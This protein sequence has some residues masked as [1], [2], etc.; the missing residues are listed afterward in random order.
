MKPLGKVAAL[1]T[2]ALFSS[3]SIADTISINRMDF[4]D[5]KSR[6]FKANEDQKIEVEYLAPVYYRNEENNN[7]DFV[8]IIDLDTRELIW[9]SRHA[10]AIEKADNKKLSVFGESLE[11]EKGRYGVFY[12]TH[13]FRMESFS[14]VDF[15]LFGLSSL[16]LEKNRISYDDVNDFYLDVRGTDL[17]EIDDKSPIKPFGN[18]QQIV[19]LKKV[20]KNRFKKIGI[21]V[22][23]ATS[24]S[25]YA[26]GEIVRNE[27]A[28]IAWLKDTTTGKTIW[29][30]DRDSTIPAGGAHKNRQ[31]RDSI[32]VDKGSYILSYSSDGSHHYKDWNSQP[33]Y[34]PVSWGVQVFAP[35]NAS[36]STF[37]PE[38]RKNDSQLLALTDIGDNDYKTKYFNLA[39]NSTIRVIA[40]GERYDREK[41]AD[42][43]WIIDAKTH[44]PVWEM[45]SSKTE[46]AGGASKNRI[47]DELVELPA[48]QYALK[49]TSDDSHSFDD[50]WNASRPHDESEWG[51][52]LYA[53]NK[54]F[55]KSTFKIINEPQSN[56]IARII[57]VQDDDRRSKTFE[58]TKD[59]S[60]RVYAIGE[61]DSDEMYDYGYIKNVDTGKRVW[62]MYA[63][64][65]EH[66]GGAGKNRKVNDII[67]LK[68]G[69][70]KVYYR[71]DGSHSSER[72]NA[73]PPTDRGNYGIT[74][75]D[76]SR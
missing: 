46:H 39:E 19:D 65:T 41:M 52:S 58:L 27:G 10:E 66:A 9:R 63:D 28:D 4:F 25:I 72:W 47:I 7:H 24:L 45:K 76:A 37:D 57:G 59:Q 55:D 1:L 22:D 29:V 21:D 6:Y 8:W 5:L 33:P 62:N 53:S 56:A 75:F 43:G 14:G 30:M 44:E 17:T 61:G 26:I 31:Y 32:N 70:Y 3:Q 18:Q 2:T 48:G 36:I 42:Y 68:A 69:T 60:V 15:F 23:K 12:S 11:L 71:T 51:I 73:T 13:N 67:N 20:R 34:D 64:E 35:N 16:L 49:Y 54:N 50:G 38:Q 40:L 74:V